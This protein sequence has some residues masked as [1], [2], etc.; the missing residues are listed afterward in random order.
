VGGTLFSLSFVPQSL[1]VS[2]QI[3]KLCLVNHFLDLDVNG[4]VS[5]DICLYELVRQMIVYTEL[6]WVVFGSRG[7]VL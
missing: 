4:N 6:S 1:I 3:C 5:L 7:V 2:V